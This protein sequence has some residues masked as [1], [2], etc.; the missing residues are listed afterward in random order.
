[1]NSRDLFAFAVVFAASSTVC[2]VATVWAVVELVTLPFTW[3]SVVMVA[4]CAAPTGLGAYS[5][6]VCRRRGRR[7]AQA[8]QERQS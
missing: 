4:F 3:M 7:A 8:E 2:L 6:M 1:M 5:A